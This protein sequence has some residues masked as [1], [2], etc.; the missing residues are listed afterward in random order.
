[1]KRHRF[2]HL[3]LVTEEQLSDMRQLNITPSF[4]INHIYFYGDSLSEHI[5]GSERAMRIMP[6]SAA[7]ERGHRISLHNDSP[8]YRPNPLLAIRTA[9]TRLTSSGHILGPQYKID[10]KSA[11]RAVT[12]DAA[13]QLHMDEKIGSL[14]SGKKADFVILDR[15]PFKVNEEDIH[16][17][18]I[19]ATF[20]NG[21][22]VL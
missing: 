9:V 4:H 13:W 11:I 12:I 15:D 1:M 10:L 3:A 6:L 22:K 18:Q 7:L 17:I 16:R 21:N 19:L 14:R 2:E 8:M 20:V 5:I